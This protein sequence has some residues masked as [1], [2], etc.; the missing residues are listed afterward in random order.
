MKTGFVE[1]YGR[2]AELD[3]SFD[4]EFWQAQPSQARF[5]AA[6]EL[7]V[8]ACKVRGDDVRQLRLQR[9]VEAFQCQPRA[10]L[11]EADFA[12]EGYFCQRTAGCLEG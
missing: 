6:W 9:S 4:L 12:H 10:D 11:T 2:L 3:R 5:D 1:R 8:H 7:I